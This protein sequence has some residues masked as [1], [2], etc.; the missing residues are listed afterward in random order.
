MYNC[1]VVKQYIHVD[2]QAITTNFD[3]ALT[4][5][6]IQEPTQW[7]LDKL[8]RIMLNSDHPWEP[9]S[10]NYELEGSVISPNDNKVGDDFYDYHH[11]INAEE[12][13]LDHDYSDSEVDDMTMWINNQGQRH[14]LP[15]N[16]T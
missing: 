12:L 3:K 7:N 13:H 10:I 6:P 14:L 11:Q 4:Y 2:N 15:L 16:N 1:H 8:N 5:V 9:D